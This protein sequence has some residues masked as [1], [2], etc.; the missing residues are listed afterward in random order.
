MNCRTNAFVLGFLALLASP[1][2]AAAETYKVVRDFSYLNPGGVWSY[3]SGD[4]GRSFTLVPSISDGC[5]TPGGR[6]DCFRVGNAIVYINTSGN[7]FADPGSGTVLVGDNVLMLHPADGVDA[8]V[9][10][11]A[12]RAGTYTFKGSYAIMDTSPT[13][14]APKIF[15]GA[16]DV[17]KAAFGSK[18]DVALTGPG[19]VLAKKK[20][21]GSKAFTFTRTLKAGQPVYFGVNALG[22]WLFDSTALKL[23][24]RIGDP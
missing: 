8:I 9:R 16:T 19:A 14:I 23:E 11:R 17:T 6:T 13:G 1:L 18:V 3:G 22:N 4:T 7:A 24:V 21:G 10:F 5:G 15:V 20:P 12:P 2:P